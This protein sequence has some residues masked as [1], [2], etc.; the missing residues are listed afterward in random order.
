MRKPARSSRSR[1]P[2]A[3]RCRFARPSRS[4]SRKG[5]KPEF[6]P[7]VVSQTLDDARATLASRHLQLNV[8]ERDPNDHIVADAIISQ[9]PAPGA[10]LAPGSTVNVAVS[11][12]PPQLS[13][14]D[15]GGMQLA[16]VGS[17][18]DALG[19]QTTIVYA[20]DPTAPVGTVIS[21]QPA[22]NTAL[23]KGSNVTLTVAVPGTIPDVSGKSPAQ[24]SALLENYGY[25]IGNTAYKQEGTEGTVVGTEPAAG[26]SEHPGA[27]V[28]I[29]VSGT[30]PDTQP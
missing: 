28:T 1:P 23:K 16:D 19:L 8:S 20:E 27:T 6:V 2:R 9:D 12:G 11:S 22:P 14:P 24:A 5:P 18:L 7:S 25:K 3:R 21:Q 30:S 29:Y 17:K 26:T 15:L 10:T 4:S 13:V